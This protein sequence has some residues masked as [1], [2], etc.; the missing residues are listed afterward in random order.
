MTDDPRGGLPDAAGATTPADRAAHWQADVAG[1]PAYQAQV[2]RLRRLTAAAVG[3]VWLSHQQSSRMPEL[4]ETFLMYAGTDDTLES[5][6]AI[7]G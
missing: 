3:L 6:L 5:L 4:A 7:T 2:R 1:R